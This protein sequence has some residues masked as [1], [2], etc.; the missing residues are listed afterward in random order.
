MGTRKVWTKFLHSTF[1]MI[2]EE[3]S[4]LR[5]P[6]EESNFCPGTYG[7]FFEKSTLWHEIYSS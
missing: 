6:E 3:L 7:L 4:G 2:L 1:F 5:F